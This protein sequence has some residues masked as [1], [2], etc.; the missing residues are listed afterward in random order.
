[1][2]NVVVTSGLVCR[3]PPKESESIF[4]FVDET[5]SVFFWSIRFLRDFNGLID[6]LVY[7]VCNQKWVLFVSFSDMLIDL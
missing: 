4:V 6:K 2:L 1:M 5:K 7:V 3:L